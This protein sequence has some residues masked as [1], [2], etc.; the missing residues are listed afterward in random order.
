[1]RL[2]VPIPGI[3]SNKPNN[4]TVIQITA[5]NQSILFIIVDFMVVCL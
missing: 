2:L 1:M 3:I 4:Q 5:I